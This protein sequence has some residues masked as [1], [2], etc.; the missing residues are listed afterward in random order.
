MMLGIASLAALATS[1]VPY[2]RVVRVVAE[3]QIIYA[4]ITYA[5]PSY[6]TMQTVFSQDGGRTWQEARSAPSEL[7]R[8]VT[9]P[10]VVCESTKPEV[11][12][13]IGLSRFLYWTRAQTAVL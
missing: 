12:Y 10:R 8:D 9:L 3:N 7:A 11:G 2:A 13:R 5:S 6:K 4:R 1:P